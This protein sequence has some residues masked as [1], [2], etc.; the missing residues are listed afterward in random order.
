VIISEHISSTIELYDYFEDCFED[1]FEDYFEDCFEDCFEEYYDYF[2]AYK[3]ILLIG[4]WLFDQ[5]DRPPRDRQRMHVGSI[6]FCDK[7]GYN[8]RSDADKT[9]IL[10]HIEE[11]FGVRVLKKHHDAFDAS[12]DM[13][14]IQNSPHMASFRTNG[15]PYY[16]YLTYSA[17]R[18]VETC[19]F[20]DKKIQQGYFLPRMIL[21]KLLFDG[22]V[23]H[24]GD[25]LMEG[26]MVRRH[27]GTWLFLVSDL[28]VD[29]GQPLG[30]VNLVRRINRLYDLL[31]KHWRK[32]AMDLFD[33]QVKKYF[34]VTQAQKDMSQVLPTLDYTCRGIYFKPFFLKF[35]D[36]LLNFD[37]SLVKKAHRPR[38]KDASNF[39]LMDEFGHVDSKGEKTEV[40][41]GRDERA[42]VK[43]IAVSDAVNDAVNDDNDERIVKA[44]IIGKVSARVFVVKKTSLP[45]V[46]E[47]YQTVADVAKK[48]LYQHACVPSLALSKHLRT[49]F[50]DLGVTD[51]VH[52]ECELH[53]GFQK[54]VPLTVRQVSAR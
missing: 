3:R 14:T 20:I 45:D 54:W 33:V 7:V 39:L 48:R 52:M 17:D 10:Q 1:C 41:H 13:R 35:R 21:T 50:A 34:R 43:L 51:V 9:K 18:F 26:E 28:L 37:D 24:Q 23:F 25:T 32:D 47:L 8:I 5:S 53:T 2:E 44:E 19:I 22:A 46:Y 31:D 4:P 38:F 42:E 29:R 6:S 49:V 15:N 16:L 27:D 40:A 30:N 12:R 36:I 11:S